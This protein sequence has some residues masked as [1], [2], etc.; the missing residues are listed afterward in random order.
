VL[1]RRPQPLIADNMR[2]AQIDRK[3]G[4]ISTVDGRLAIRTISAG[5]ARLAVTIDTDKVEEAVLALLFLTFPVAFVRSRALSAS[6]CRKWRVAWGAR[7]V[8][9]HL[10][11]PTRGA[12]RP[13]D[14]D[15]PGLYYC[16]SAREITTARVVE[17]LQKSVLFFVTDP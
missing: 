3:R 10:I 2:E 9:E 4:L 1:E 15:R 12:V 13:P 14:C 5:L 8:V 11:A 6:A 16:Q 17:I 7:A